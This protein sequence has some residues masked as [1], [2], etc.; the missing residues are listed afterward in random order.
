MAV[1]RRQFLKDSA[2]LATVAAIKPEIANPPR[3]PHSAGV[4]PQSGITFTRSDNLI[5]I[6]LQNRITLDF[7][8]HNNH[9][10]GISSVLL[11]GK[12]LRNTSQ[13]I[14]PEISTPY[15]EV[16][17]YFELIDVQAKDGS[18]VV[19]TRPYFTVG[20]RMVWTEHALHPL[21]NTAPWNA[22]PTSP[23]GTRLDWVIREVNETYDNVPY[24]GFSYGFCY[25]APQHPIYQ[26]EDKA[27]WELGG[28]IVGNGFIMRGANYPHTRFKEDTVLYS[29]WY[30]PGIANPHVFQH[31]PL[32][33]Q[34][35][36]FTFQYDAQHVLLTV[37][38]RP[39]HVRALYQRT[40]N[41]PALLHFNQFCFDLTTTIATA[42]RK[43]LVGQRTRQSETTL[44]NH[45][46]RTR[47]FLQ[48]QHRQFYGLRYDRAR[49]T[50]HVE[51]WAIVKM[52]GFQLIF[53]QLKTW[54]VNRTFIMPLWRSTETDINPRFKDDRKRF[55]VFG[56]MC[57]MLELEIAD[58]YGG[59][60]G[61]RKL[62]DQA[63]FIHLETY[64]W[65]GTHFSSM[66]PLV[67]QNP[68]MFCRDQCGQYNRNNY[69]HVLFAANQRNVKYQEYAL[70]SY[71]RLKECGLTGLFHDSHF[72][73]A[74]DTINFL[75]DTKAIPWNPNQPAPFQTPVDLKHADQ[76]VTMHDT[77]LQLQQK[78]QV[79]IGMVYYVESEGALGTPMCGTDYENTRG[80]E[81]I[82]SNMES[83]LD[84]DKVKTF[85]DD[86]TTAYFRAMA[87]R[88]MFA[89]EINP[90]T[91]PD[92]KSISPWWNAETMAPLNHAFNRVEN[93]LEQMWVLEDDCGIMWAGN[94]GKVIFAYK[95]FSYPFESPVI[96]Y[97][98]HTDKRFP[99]QKSLEAKKFGIYRL[100]A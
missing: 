30:F 55:G 58:A 11:N 26:I 29:G 44:A 70:T 53:Q 20:H 14:W 78:I 37:H 80:N 35:Q 67:E 63:K 18:I 10:L 84:F 33:T 32:Y 82:Y 39:S 61:F 74:T 31:K 83:G 25:Q 42:P 90:D 76:I 87:A 48:E 88:L 89:P 91:F 15:A 2:A 47:D 27:T 45:Y 97:D 24:A 93:D 4:D 77:S 57:T 54:G 81:Y 73:L 100:E 41:Q 92:S 59:W 68:E 60:D 34:M 72:N 9:V 62:M 8:L 96:V 12:P 36:G 16:A 50:A 64:M 85:G 94:G 13:P 66:S 99:A 71:K 51:T 98:A 75:H 22:Q 79:G 65:F 69:G 56:N 49:P 86:P 6:S 3:S 7:L 46:L 19:S 52:D 38:E 40:S 43:I 23:E 21:I 5:H 1:S 28:H 95:D 17:A